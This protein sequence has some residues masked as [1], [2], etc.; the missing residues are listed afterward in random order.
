MNGTGNYQLLGATRDDAAGEAFD[1]VAKLL[2]LGYPGGIEID[3]RARTGDPDAFD[4][5]KTM[6][7]KSTGFDFSFSG[8]KTAA[9]NKVKTQGLPSGQKLNDFCASFQKSVVEV[10]VRK[11]ID[12]AKANHLKDI[13][14]CGGVAANSL[15]RAEMAAKCEEHGF[16]FYRPSPV[17]CTDNAAMIAA[18]GYRRLKRGESSPYDLPAKANLPLGQR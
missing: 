14:I 5:P 8:L 6:T 11:T 4:F 15:L 10:L 2:G 1:K 17:F 7:K 12:S 13:Q 9:L 3:K 18:A 16:K